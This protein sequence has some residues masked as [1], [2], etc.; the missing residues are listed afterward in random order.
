MGRKKAS[1]VTENQLPF[2]GFLPE[3]EKTQPASEKKPR[4]PTIRPTSQEME[5]RE[6]VEYI[7]SDLE[8]KG[9]K[10]VVYDSRF[11]QTQKTSSGV[12]ENVTTGSAKIA[13]VKSFGDGLHDD[14]TL[15][16]EASYLQKINS[17]GGTETQKIV[18]FK[19]HEGMYSTVPFEMNTELS[20]GKVSEIISESDYESPQG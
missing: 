20:E 5:L 13:A 14:Q 6:M 10:C 12:R 19:T 3:N 11:E 4:K 16:V 15:L 8:S 7:V 18:H 2:D 1:E 9:N 17:Q